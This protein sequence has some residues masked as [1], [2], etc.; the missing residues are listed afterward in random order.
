MSLNALHNFYLNLPEP[1]RGCFMALRDF[2][3]QQNVHITP[4]W[5]YKLPCFYYKGKMLCYLW[6]HKTYKSPYVGFILGSVLDHP[7]LL[8]EKRKQGKIL[9]VSPTE[10]LPV[11][12][13]AQCIE[14]VI[15]GLEQ[16]RTR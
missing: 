5:K 9:L 2:I 13:L 14:A 15:E 6:Q 11:A 8:Q 1:E 16:K 3:L 7:A 4:E 10:D 12:L